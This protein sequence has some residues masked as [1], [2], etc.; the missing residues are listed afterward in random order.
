MSQSIDSSLRGQT[1]QDEILIA[2]VDRLR[3]QIEE[4]NEQNCWESDDPV[5]LSHPGGSELCTVSFGPGQFPG[6][7]FSGAGSD[8]LTEAASIIVAPTVPLTGDRP[9]RRARRIHK[10][11]DGRSLLHR[12][13]QVLAAL[14]GSP[15]EPHLDGQPLLRDMPS[16]GRCTQPGEVMVGDARMLQIQITIQTVFDWDLNVAQ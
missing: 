4:Y 13:R 7:F 9:R 3:D 6:E 5:P 11:P 12:K 15:W 14:F 8:T 1:T 10:D 2:F 16:P